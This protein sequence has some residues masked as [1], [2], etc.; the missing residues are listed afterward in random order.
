MTASDTNIPVTNGAAR[1]GRENTARANP[2]AK[3]PLVR[4]R[5]E[6]AVFK[7]NSTW[8][9]SEATRIRATAHATVESLLNRRKK[10]SLLPGIHCFTKSIVE[11]EDREVRAELTEDIAAER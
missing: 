5:K 6:K 2:A 11:T 9:L 4:P 1:P 10:A 8:R 3:A 7:T